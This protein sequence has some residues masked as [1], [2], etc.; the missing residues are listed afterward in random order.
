MKIRKT[1][2][3]ALLCLLLCGC[4]R[5]PAPDAVPKDDTPPEVTDTA[6]S[7]ASDDAEWKQA[8]A[9]YL[10][11]RR[12]ENYP[13]RYA[14]IYLDDDEIPEII[15][16]GSCEAEGTRILNYSGG[17]VHETQLRRLYFSFIPWEN[18]LL[19]REGNM[20][21]YTADIYSIID[22]KMT[23]I[24]SGTQDETD[25]PHTPDENGE[26]E[27]KYNY[28]WNGESVS[29]EEYEAA[30][31]AAFDSSLALDLYDYYDYTAENNGMCNTEEIIEQINAL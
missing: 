11:E 4:G 9:D 24:S 13:Y 1:L 6:R 18:L 19:N 3:L 21:H 27:I 31:G 7:P 12:D 16:M 15:D 5:E 30:L 8:Y 23:V 10:S 29:A 17:E 22:G 25:E 14:L 26:F 20:G 28:T 2:S